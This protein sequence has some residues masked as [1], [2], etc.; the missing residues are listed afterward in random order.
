MA[1]ISNIVL[2]VHTSSLPIFRF[3]Q[4]NIHG[5]YVDR[6]LFINSFIQFSLYI[7]DLI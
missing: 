1:A 5:D 2:F 3:K 7:F 4:I 6:I